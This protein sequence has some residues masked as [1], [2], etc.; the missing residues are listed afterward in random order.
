MTESDVNALFSFLCIAIDITVF[1]LTKI[2]YLVCW[3]IDQGWWFSRDKGEKTRVWEQALIDSVVD[4][5]DYSLFMLPIQF[6]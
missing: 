6:L 3:Q 5:C 2:F 4:V 1:I